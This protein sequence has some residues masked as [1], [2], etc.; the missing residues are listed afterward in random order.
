M[1]KLLSNK[2]LPLLQSCWKV[3]F[4]TS[5]R[6]HGTLGHLCGLL[7]RLPNAKNPKK[8]LHACCDALFL[9]LKGHILAVACGELGISN[10]DAEIPSA[11]SKGGCSVSECRSFI[12]TLAVKVMNRCSIVEGAILNRNVDDTSDSVY[13][14][15]RV[16]CHLASLALE[17]TD[18]WREGD[19]IRVLRC[20]RINLLHFF[21]T[22]R[23][24][25][26]LEALRIQ[27]QL[28]IL[29]PHLVNQLTWGR[30]VNTQGGAGNNIPCDLHNEH[31]VRICKDAIHCMGSNFS[32]EAATRVAR[33]VT[34]LDNIAHCFDV[35]CGVN[36]ESS[37]H[38]TKSEEEDLRRAVK[39]IQDEKIWDITP[40][41][42]YHNFRRI[43]SN[44]LKHLD[45]KKLNTWIG[46]KVKEC[47][48]YRRLIIEEDTSDESEDDECTSD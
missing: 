2:H 48:K 23:T 34:T 22:Q 5:S 14:Y 1:P 16:L 46:N 10:P 4:T 38:T 31:V 24:K 13:N 18:A 36:N 33:S 30:F 29:P 8:D 25:Y 15:A 6:D 3:L 35:Q 41:R 37:S 27:F 26:A 43:S 7:G 9:I 21:A 19:G 44:P 32:Q 47:I 42:K 40:G 28:A 12:E 39:V 20:W 11:P 17:L 45:W